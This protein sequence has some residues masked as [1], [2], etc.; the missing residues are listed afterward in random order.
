MKTVLDPQTI[1]HY[2][3]NKTQLE[4]KNSNR[5]FYF[6]GD[7]IYSYGSHFPIATHYKNVVLFT[8][9]SYSVSTAKH[10][11]LV[12]SACSHLNKVYC[13]NPKDAVNGYHEENIKWWINDIKDAFK[14]L[15]TARK[16]QKYANAIESTL[17]QLETYCE[18]F[19]VKFTAEQKKLL[20]LAKSD[21]ETLKGVSKEAQLIEVKAKELKVKQAGKAYAKYLELWRKYADLSELLTDKERNLVNYYKNNTDLN[22]TLLRTNSKEVETSKGVKIPIEI[23]KRIFV[24]YTKKVSDG[25][26][27]GCGDW[28]ILEYNV[29]SA[30]SNNLVV[31]CHNVARTEIDT[32]AKQMNWIN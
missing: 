32:I 9:R 31:G 29:T 6:Y 15:A 12:R 16:P 28:K 30:D 14:S 21:F 2:F 5:S 23:A 3:A 11:N 1:A 19:K 13:A 27:V 18:L 7:T 17:N 24:T 26:C 8:L 4:G 22:V 10:I 25:G 20:K